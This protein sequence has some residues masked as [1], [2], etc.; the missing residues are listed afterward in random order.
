MISEKNI[1]QDDGERVTFGYI[2]G[3]SG[4]Y[5]TRTVPGEEFLDVV[6]DAL[7]DHQRFY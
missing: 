4:D 3:D 2:E 5:K 6:H 7:L 1:L